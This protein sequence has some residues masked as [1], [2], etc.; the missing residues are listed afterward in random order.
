MPLF[1]CIGHAENPIWNNILDVITE[2]SIY[3]KLQLL[4]KEDKYI[5]VG[6]S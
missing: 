2:C 4:N 5:A 3:G 6:L 1:R